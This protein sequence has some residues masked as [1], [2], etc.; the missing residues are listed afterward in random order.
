MNRPKTVSETGLPTPSLQPLQQLVAADMA[1]VNAVILEKVKSDAALIGELATYIVSAGGK[2][3][4]PSLTLACAGLCGYRGDRHV[5]LAA[6]V[7]FIHTATLLH[8][9]VVDESALRRGRPTANEVW[10]NQSSVLVGDFLFSRSFQLMVADGSLEVLR[11]L[12]DAAAT[13]SEGEV[14]QLMTAHNPETTE[15]QYLQV[16]KGKTAALF[17]AACEIG[18]V[19][20][21]QAEAAQKLQE[22]GM[23]LGI[24][25]QLVD[26]ALDYSANQEA[27]GKSVGDDFREGKITLPVILSYQAATAD[28]KAFFQRT[29]GETK[30]ENHDLEQAI[31]ILQRYG[32]IEQT[33]QRAQD[34]ANRAR[35]AL[36][37]FPSNK[38][39][40]ALEEAVDFC[41]SRAY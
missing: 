28:E 6:C 23:N 4:R 41:I 2:R 38:Y 30:Y 25:F 39:R 20:M 13:I 9:D 14:K 8:D 40:D 26:D 34:Y 17:S 29:L 21:E 10:S 12:S 33:F 18:A 3:I 35:Y 11:I 16:I 37:Y 22:F 32:A 24:A 7:E 36:S 19:I 1:R 5:N 27:L 31:D 15:E